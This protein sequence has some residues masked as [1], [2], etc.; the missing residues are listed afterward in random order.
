MPISLKPF[1]MT[2]RTDEMRTYAAY[3]KLLR[4]SLENLVVMVVMAEC[5]CDLIERCSD[6]GWIE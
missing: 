4:L 2:V 3:D 6:D 5:L 1:F